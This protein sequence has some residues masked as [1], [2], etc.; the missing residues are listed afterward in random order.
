[1]NLVQWIG[2]A[3]VLLSLVGLG[4]FVWLTWFKGSTAGQSTIGKY[5][6]AALESVQL[7]STLG[8]VELLSHVDAV[9]ASPEA[10]RACDVIA[11]VLWAAAKES[12]KTAQT[13]P[14]VALVAPPIASAADIA[15][16]QAQ[17][18]ALKPVP[19]ATSGV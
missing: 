13:G 1:M 12:W 10:A 18:N 9:E 16:L 14:T 19:Q 17:I 5:I 8:Y 3:V 11:D 15:S 7:T 2:I 6:T 4:V